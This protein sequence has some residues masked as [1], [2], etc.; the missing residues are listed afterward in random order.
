MIGV[1]AVFT[2]HLNGSRRAEIN[3]TLPDFLEEELDIEVTDG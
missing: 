3:L 2:V 1:D